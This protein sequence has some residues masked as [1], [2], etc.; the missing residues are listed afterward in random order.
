MI[1]LGRNSV[2]PFTDKQ[3]ELVTTFADQA[4]IAIEN[5]RLFEAE[6][7]RTRSCAKSLEQQTATSEVLK[8]IS[9]RPANS[10]RYFRAM[11]GECVRSLCEAN[12]RTSLYADGELLRAGRCTTCRMPMRSCGGSEPV[13]VPGPQRLGRAC[14][15]T[16]GRFIHLLRI[17]R[18][19][20]YPTARQ[21]RLGGVRTLLACRC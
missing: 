8:V 21:T 14:A 9:A 2:R 5:T 20:R 7:Q 15:A 18:R 16:Q 4:V 13:T 11:L 17:D 1:V 12:R 19:R 3:I 10:N 6:Q